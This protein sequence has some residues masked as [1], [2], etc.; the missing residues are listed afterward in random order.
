MH[1]GLQVRP[2]PPKAPLNFLP[3]M[4]RGAATTT[5]PGRAEPP[6]DRARTKCPSR[7]FGLWLRERAAALGRSATYFDVPS[8]TLFE[9]LGKQLEDGLGAEAPDA[10]LLDLVD[11]PPLVALLERL[12]VADQWTQ[13]RMGGLFQPRTYP[14]RTDPDGDA[15]GYIGWRKSSSPTAP[16]FL[17]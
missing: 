3:S 11:P 1:S 6:G 8:A 9:G 4:N 7:A 12:L 2:E 14:P 5:G 15:R 17:C 13:L 10:V 16:A